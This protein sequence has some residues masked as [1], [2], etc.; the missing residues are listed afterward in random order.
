MASLL[1]LPLFLLA[2]LVA[3]SPNQVAGAP[4][5]IEAWASPHRSLGSCRRLRIG[6]CRGGD[7]TATDRQVP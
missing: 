4:A 7:R 3:A 2:R 1:L 6:T 5:T